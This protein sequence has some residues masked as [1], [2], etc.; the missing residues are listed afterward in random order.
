MLY[1]LVASRSISAKV[2]RLL[3]RLLSPFFGFD[4]REGFLAGDFGETDFG[5]EGRGED[6]IVSP[7]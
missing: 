1:P 4:D 6:V 7:T 5:A 3:I 2:I